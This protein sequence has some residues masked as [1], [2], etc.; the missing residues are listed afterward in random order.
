MP[1]RTVS[2]ISAQIIVQG[3]E[4]LAEYV[5]KSHAGA[6]QRNEI[7]FNGLGVTDSAKRANTSHNLVD[8]RN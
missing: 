2:D 3:I 4:R 7:H 5:E 6:N 1:F 8:S